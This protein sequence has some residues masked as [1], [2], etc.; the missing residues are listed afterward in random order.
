MLWRVSLRCIAF[1]SVVFY[2]MLWCCVV[3]WSLL[4]CCVIGCAS[5]HHVWTTQLEVPLVAFSHFSTLPLATLQSSTSC[6]YCCCRCCPRGSCW[7][8]LASTCA[9]AHLLLRLRILCFHVPFFASQCTGAETTTKTKAYLLA[10]VPFPSTAPHESSLKSSWSIDASKLAPDLLPSTLLPRVLL[11]KSGRRRRAIGSGSLPSTLLRWRSLQKLVVHR[12]KQACS[13]PVSVNATYQR[14]A[15]E[16][17]PSTP[18]FLLQPL[19]R[20]R[21]SPWGLLRQLVVRRHNRTCSRP[22]PRNA[23]TQGFAHESC[24]SSCSSSSSSSC[25][26]CCGY[27]CSAPVV[28]PLLRLLLRLLPF[29]LCM[30]GGTPA[31]QALSLRLRQVDPRA[32]TGRSRPD[33][34]RTRTTTAN[35]TPLFPLGKVGGAAA[36][37]V[38]VRYAGFHATSCG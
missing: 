28:A 18:P 9:V 16:D 17:S 37:A 4:L 3:L 12:R 30:H 35:S 13:G 8:Y 19:F 2:C 10:P 33:T 11:R 7:C 34:R 22:A 15:Q 25:R 26:C 36:R 23:T 5:W 21:Y 20:Q 32:L 6:C 29:L 27:C 24:S 1:S 31:S 38:A 14:F